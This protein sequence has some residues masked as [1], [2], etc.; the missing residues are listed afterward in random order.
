MAYVFAVVGSSGFHTVCSQFSHA[1]V[2][3][4]RG[5]RPKT[6]RL[7]AGVDGKIIAKRLVT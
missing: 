3:V 1:F 2:T 5:D 7:R 4:S 6:N